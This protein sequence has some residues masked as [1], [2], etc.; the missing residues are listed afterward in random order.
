[1]AKK[2]AV[3][4]KMEIGTTMS[5]SEA[6]P[7]VEATIKA[8]RSC[9][10]WGPPGLGKTSLINQ[11]GEKLGMEVIVVRAVL[12]DPVDL[13][14]IPRITEEEVDGKM[15][16]V[17][18]WIPPKF[19]P[20]NPNSKAIIF[21][22][23]LPQ[24]PA[25]S[26]SACL[27]LLD[28]MVGDRRIPEGVRIVAAGN[29]SSDRA[30]AHNLI[31]PLL[32]RFAAHIELRH[33]FEDWLSWAVTHDIRPEVT[34]YNQY[35]QGGSLMGFD[36]QS[37]MKAFPTPRSWE[38][39]SDMLKVTSKDDNLFSWRKVASSCIGGAAAN[40]FVTYLK[41]YHE[42]P[43]LDDVLSGKANDLLKK[44]KGSND[45]VA[46]QWALTGMVQEAMR[47]TNNKM[48]KHDRNSKEYKACLEKVSKA[49]NFVMGL[50]EEIHIACLH[51]ILKKSNN[52]DFL[53][54]IANL[55]EIS[56]ALNRIKDYVI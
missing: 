53:G 13:R 3:E 45:W 38:F 14:G 5:L 23:E 29:R 35:K 20:T 51:I 49:L 28:R 1:M 25:M 56:V 41:I 27:Q 30:G 37:N 4:E 46:I 50:D 16:T 12:L 21:L 44:K 39:L 36:P 9:F 34:S 33:D 52:K 43:T 24:A 18:E 26:Q 32:N 40:E 22:D 11:I 6:M 54:R 47:E 19:I 31:T 55:P 48:D 7:V 8:N 2:N 10:L 17:T 15:Q 42:L